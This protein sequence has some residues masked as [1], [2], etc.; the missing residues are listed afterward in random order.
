MKADQRKSGIRR[1]RFTRRTYHRFARKQILRSDHRIELLDGV[2]YEPL[3]MSD[4]HWRVLNHLTTLFV[5]LSNG[6]WFATCR[7]PIILDDHSEPDPDI[8]LVRGTISN[9]REHVPTAADTL[10]AIEVSDDTLR[11]DRGRR[12]RVYAEGGIPE[13]WLINLVEHV[14]QVRTDPRPRSDESRGTYAVQRTYRA[15][16]KVP[17]T[18]DARV[19]ADV[20]VAELIPL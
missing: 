7:S 1:L 14:V 16:E 10:I 5:K 3:T 6:G 17:L 11:F 20:P 19:I 9:Y 8:A 12:L 4:S 18:L 13:Y 2:I 15:D